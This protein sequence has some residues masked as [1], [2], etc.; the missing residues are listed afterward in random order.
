MALPP[1]EKVTHYQTEDQPTK[2]RLPGYG[3]EKGHYH[4]AANN[5]SP[6]RK[7]DRYRDDENSQKGEF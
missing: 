1:P 7:R 3:W 5:D 2:M 4:E 6:K